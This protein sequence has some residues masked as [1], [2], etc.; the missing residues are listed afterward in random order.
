M[1]YEV[2]SVTIP[3]SAGGVVYDD[4]VEWVKRH[5]R[6]MVQKWPQT[7]PRVYANYTGPTG[8]IHWGWCF[9]SLATKAALE[10]QFWEDAGYRKSWDEVTAIEKK[11]GT[12]FLT[13]WTR[14]LYNIL[15]A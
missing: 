9:E 13:H 10:A 1:M 2:L 3:D 14:S 7:E 11:H 8:Q 6:Y 12:P 4:A 5:L 15:E